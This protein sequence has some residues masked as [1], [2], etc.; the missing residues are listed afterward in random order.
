MCLMF[1]S[2]LA[3]SVSQNVV[4]IGCSILLSG[5]RL[6]LNILWSL[7]ATVKASLVF[8]LS[9]VTW[10]CGFNKYY[11]YINFGLVCSA[12]SCYILHPWEDI[13][14]GKVGAWIWPPHTYILEKRKTIKLKKELFI[15]TNFHVI[16][17]QVL[18]IVNG[19]Y[20]QVL[21]RAT[22]NRKD[23]IQYIQ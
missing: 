19:N 11:R 15:N 4:S 14:K 1:P 20:K 16:T 6:L 13:I 7:E 2:C 22:Q 18:N 9:D 5:S 12:T 10:W 8:F 21:W 23:K 3:V 17:I